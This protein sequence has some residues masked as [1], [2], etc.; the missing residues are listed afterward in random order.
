MLSG[1][2][3]VLAAESATFTNFIYQ[4]NVDMPVA[5]GGTVAMMKFTADT[6]TLSGDVKFSVTQDGAT[7]VQTGDT[8]AF[9]GG[10]TFY[11]TQMSGSLLGVQLTFT[12]STAD[13]VF[14]S[15]LANPV[16]ATLIPS[17]T[18]S[19]T[20]ANQSLAVAGSVH[21]IPLSVGLGG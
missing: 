18:L 12:P 14:L 9:S 4:G 6:I 11:A 17:L 21:Y 2:T 15:L 20:S 8:F 10:V 16:T 1:A 5:G 7:V 19:N 3:T 13:A